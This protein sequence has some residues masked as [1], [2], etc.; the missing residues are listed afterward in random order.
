M[1]RHAEI[2]L[3]RLPQIPARMAHPASLTQEAATDRIIKEPLS[4]LGYFTEWGGRAWERLVRIGIADYLGGDLRGLSI[5]DFGARYGRMSCLFALLG[6]RVTGVDIRAECL[7]RARAEARHLGVSDQIDF[8]QY[9]GNIES[10]PRHTYDVVFSK[11]VLVLVD[12]RPLV[13]RAMKRLLK[14]DGRIV[15]IENGLGNAALRLARRIKHRGKWDYTRAHYFTAQDARLLRR[16][17]QIEHT[18]RS[19]I[20]PIYLFCGKIGREFTGHRLL[21][22]IPRR[23]A[24]ERKDVPSTV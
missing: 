11:S 16:E 9:D 23:V 24:Q 12:N 22:S 6:A 7:E 3:T 21:V 19:F 5:L 15:F 17:Y 1:G 4:R 2:S 14:T 20:P 10:L 18:A 8:I 13:L